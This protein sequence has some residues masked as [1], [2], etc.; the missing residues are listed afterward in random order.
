MKLRGFVLYLLLVSPLGLMALA[1]W[2][3][4]GHSTVFSGLLS[5]VMT[6][7]GVGGIVGGFAY[8]YDEIKRARLLPPSRPKLEKAKTTKRNKYFDAIV[9]RLMKR[10]VPGE[11]I[12][13]AGAQVTPYNFYYKWLRLSAFS[14][15]GAL[16]VAFVLAFVLRSPLPFGVLIVP[17][18]MLFVLPNLSLKSSAGDRKRSIDDELPFFSLYM[19]T[20]SDVGV[21]LYS[22][23]KRLVGKGIFRYIEQDA[24][25][26]V[27][28]V[29]FIGQDQLTAIDNMARH[30]ASRNMQDLLYGYSS[31]MRSGG[32]ISGYFTARAGEL[33]NWLQFRFDKYSDAVSDLGE[34]MM[35][36]FFI[37][38]MIVIGSAFISPSASLSLVWIMAALVIPS[39]GVMMV[40]IIRSAQPKT[41]DYYNGNNYMAIAAA[42]I[43]GV[44]VAF[45][46]HIA[47]WAPVA[48]AAAA[49]SLA[50]GVPVMVQKR[51]GAQEEASLPSFIRDITEYRKSGYDVA[52]AIVKLSKE[53]KYTPAFTTLLRGLATG[54]QL[55]EKL[56]EVKIHSNSWLVRQVFFILDEIHDSGG[57]SPRELEFI[58]T[59]VEKY[60]TAKKMVKSR[61]RIYEMLSMGTPVG[62]AVVIFV[63]STFL[64]TFHGFGSSA[65]GGGLPIGGLNFL[66]TTIP[67]S[68]F[69]AAY[70]MVIDSAIFMALSAGVA[71]D[72]TAKNTW[73]ITITVLITAV[74]I[75]V[76][77]TFGS[78][79]TS[80]LP[81]SL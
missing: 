6:G 77:T 14:F 13:R 1:G 34:M 43:S 54:L 39:A 60:S 47:L 61:M 67:P 66:N 29:E 25:Y 7:S 78:A 36:M 12:L 41:G 28:A 64:G 53:G 74:V 5:A 11:G 51:L 21:S 17:A 49:G 40:F 68:L 81:T 70:I 42:A 69:T 65:P 80:I 20:L 18:L 59:F 73:R 55:G 32:D 2:V 45:I 26:L 22:G 15:I 52:R 71:S 30:H 57:G 44:I 76:I 48:A 23:M 31:E 63:M 9:K 24:V 3:L 27:R 72:F 37:F 75:F 79:L 8:Y 58:H 35:A 38:P 62:L 19:A 56:S 10:N 4:V 46:P 50:Y 16:P 33:L